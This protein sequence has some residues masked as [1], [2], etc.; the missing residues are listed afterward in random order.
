M[1]GVIGIISKNVLAQEDIGNLL[2]QSKIRGQH[3][4]GISY[5]QDKMLKNKII[6]KNAEHIELENVH[7]KKTYW[8]CKIQHF[9]SFVQPTNT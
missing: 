2:V 1:C 3:A 5:I 9:I 4:T 6:P 7:T 8:S